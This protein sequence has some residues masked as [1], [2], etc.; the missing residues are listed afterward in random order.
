MR[1]A[2]SRS[3]AATR[4]VSTTGELLQVGV[5]HSFVPGAVRLEP[6][7]GLGEPASTGSRTA[8]MDPDGVAGDGIEERVAHVAREVDDVHLVM[9]GEAQVAAEG[10]EVEVFLSQDGDVH[11]R[12]R[13]HAAATRPGAEEDG[14]MDILASPQ[15]LA[16]DGPERCGLLRHE[17][18]FIRRPLS[19]SHPNVIRTSASCCSQR[20]ASRRCRTA[21]TST[22]FCWSSTL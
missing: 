13:P 3:L 16:Q 7:Q 22:S 15:G 5:A 19:D 10:E 1:S 21:T 9:R 2:S 20:Y 18:Q 14:E 6:G 12:V 4:L 8:L 11:V 17:G